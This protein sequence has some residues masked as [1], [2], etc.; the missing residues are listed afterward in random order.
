M[1]F[2]PCPNCS[3]DNN[4]IAPTCVYCGAQIKEKLTPEDEKKINDIRLSIE[5]DK[6]R[7]ENEVFLCCPKCY[8][9]N[10]TPMKKG[11]SFGKAAAGFFTLGLYGI[12]AGSI[13]SGNIKLFCGGCGHTFN[14][15][16]AISLNKYQQKQ[17]KKNLR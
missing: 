1:K 17:F 15:G 11:F 10:L 3:R 6:I 4:D 8:G 5:M 12:V 2:V 7:K 16:I 14:S 9:S 13:G